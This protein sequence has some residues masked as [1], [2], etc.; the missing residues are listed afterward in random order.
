MLNEKSPNE[1][2]QILFEYTSLDG[3]PIEGSKCYDLGLSMALE[4]F[5]CLK[6]DE[7]PP[8]DLSKP[9]KLILSRVPS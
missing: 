2:I 5:A 3:R 7:L 6:V 1:Q 8:A 4:L 9:Y